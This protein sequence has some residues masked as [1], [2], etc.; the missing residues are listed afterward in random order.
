MP[1]YASMDPEHAVDFKCVNEQA[2]E[3]ADNW[4]EN[5][6]DEIINIMADWLTGP[7]DDHAS[8]KLLRLITS[9]AELIADRAKVYQ[10]E[11]A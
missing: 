1:Y 9:R 5:D 7:Q 2:G 4:H 11:P 3:L 6:H 10:G 8:A